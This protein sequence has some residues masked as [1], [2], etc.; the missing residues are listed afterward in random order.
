MM[1]DFSADDL[2]PI[3]AL[4]VAET[5][6]QIRDD[7]AKV[8]NRLGFTEP[9]A[10]SLLGRQLHC[11]TP[12]RTGPKERLESIAGHDQQRTAPPQ[13]R[14]AES[15]HVGVCSENA[16]LR[17]GPRAGEAEP[18]S[19][20]AARTGSAREDQLSADCVL[21]PTKMKEAPQQRVVSRCGALVYESEG[22]GT[23]TPN[24]RIDSPVL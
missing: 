16:R 18:V 3:V 7:Q 14:V 21:V 13:S 12:N 5:L 6:E 2:R 20:W 10:A 4:A 24:H 8:G 19:R 17:Y 23:R 15:A 22:E 11:S 1:I 9:E